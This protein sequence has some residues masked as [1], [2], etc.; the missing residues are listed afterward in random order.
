MYVR[1]TLYV[2]VCVTVS[3]CLTVCMYVC[4]CMSVRLSECVPLFVRPSVHRMT[5]SEDH[6]HTN[7]TLNLLPYLLY[8]QTITALSSS[9]CLEIQHIG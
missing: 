6:I 8:F 7:I 5:T 1:V 4:V 9:Y 2:S 3:V